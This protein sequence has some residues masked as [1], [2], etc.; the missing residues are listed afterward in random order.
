LDNK[1]GVIIQARTGSS[2]FRNKI[3]KKIMGKP[4]LYHI[5][6]R[7]QQA[8]RISKIIVATTNKNEDRILEKITS[9][10]NIPIFFGSNNDVLDRY[11][12][13]ARTFNFL[14]IV[15]ITADCP[16]IDPIIIDKTIDRFNS[17]S[18][19]YVS[20]CLTRTFPEGMSVEVFT[21]EALKKSWHDSVWLSEREHVTPYMWKNPDIFKSAELLNEKGNQSHIRITVDYP[22]DFKLIKKIYQSL[23]P[24]NPYF[25]LPDIIKF[26]AENPLLLKINNNIPLL[27]GY[28]ASLK[29]DRKIKAKSELT[30]SVENNE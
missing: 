18:Y 9:A 7:V 30:S 5:I 16:V 17:S 12:Q 23:Y 19:D 26:L 20:N 15:R 22:S 11:Y 14:N 1:V 4:I 13:A 24:S 28:E 3:G 21:F 10:C 29:N 8:R 2:R 6:R 27:E 25:L